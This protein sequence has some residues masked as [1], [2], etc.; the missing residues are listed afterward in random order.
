MAGSTWRTPSLE[1]APVTS[2]PK[3]ASSFASAQRATSFVYQLEYAP[4]LEPLDSQFVSFASGGGTAGKNG[5]LGTLPLA[6]IASHLP[7]AAQGI[8]P[9]DPYQYAFTVRLRVIDNLGNLGEDRKTLFA[10]HDPTLHAGWPK[11]IDSGGESSIRFGDLDGDG[12]QAIITANSSGEIAVWN[13]DGTPFTYFNGGHPFVAPVPANV[14]DHLGTAGIAGGQVQPGHGGFTTP[15]LGDLD[16][17]GLP[18]IVVNNGDKVYALRGDGTLLPG[19]PVAINP[20]FSAP[21][22]RSKTNH[23]K[24]GIFSSAV[25][26]DLDEDGRLDIV[27]AAMDQRVYAWNA[28]GQLLTGWPVFLRDRHRR[29]RPSRRRRAHERDLQGRSARAQPG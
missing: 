8:P 26:A 21:A 9:T 18:E 29:G 4:G 7:G 25:L 3:Q 14:T 17:D 15:A 24:T 23:V 11:F 13:A 19:F 1:S 6:E 22:L 28:N 10:Y 5:Q 12:V 16:G 27:V 20:A 2:H